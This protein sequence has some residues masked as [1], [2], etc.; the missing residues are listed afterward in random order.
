MIFMRAAFCIFAF[1]ICYR[2]AA[3]QIIDY[4]FYQDLAFGQH[5]IF[6]QLYPERGSIYVKDGG[7]NF[8]LAT[9]RDLT[10]IYAMPNK[11]K[12]PKDA[13]EKIANILFPVNEEEIQLDLKSIQTQIEEQ[14]LDEEE[15]TKQLKEM[16]IKEKQ[17]STIDALIASFKKPNDPYEPIKHRVEDAKVE[18]VKNLNIEGIAFA[19]ETARFYPENELASHVLGFLNPNVEKQGQYGLEGYFNKDLSGKMGHLKSEMD[20][21]GRWIATTEKEFVKAEDGKSY[22]LTIDKNIQYFV[23]QKLKEYVLNFKSEV[24]SV[25]VMD[26]NTGAIL[27]MANYPDFNPNEYNK[28]ENLNDFNND[29]IFSAYE[30]GSIFKAI[31]M[32]IALD[33]EKVN[34]STTFIDEGTRKYEDK[35]INNSDKLAHGKVTMTQVLEMSLNTGSIFAAEQAGNE[36]FRKYVKDFGFGKETGIELETERGGNISLL[37]K[38]SDIYTATASFGQGITATSLQMVKAYAALANGGKLMKPYIIEQIVN[39][40]GTIEEKKPEVLKQVIS[41]RA[42]TLLGG[43][44][45]SVVENGH[46]K[47]AGVKGYYVAGKTGTAQMADNNGKYGNDTIHTFVGF[48]PVDNPKFVMITKLTKPQGAMFSETSATP[49]F[50]DIAKFILDYYNVPKERE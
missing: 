29:A 23:T 19:K 6:Q 13:A 38:N 17:Q 18:L 26:P 25:I 31:T 22:V 30:P 15:V 40:D 11:I 28:V 5:N 16:A 21:Y 14:G 41:T 50:G 34:P 46:A 45:V 47:R 8:P 7:E 3:L 35:V 49:L 39:N 27:A 12:D 9:N 33:L 4:Q 2:L 42:S 44:L 32:A 24:G 43:M 10:L 1:L 20:P 37:E 36:T 48:A